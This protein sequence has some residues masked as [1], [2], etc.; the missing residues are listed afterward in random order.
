MMNAR[1]IEDEVAP[2]FSRLYWLKVSCHGSGMCEMV[3]IGM[4]DT[5]EP[6]V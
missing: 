5:A 1:T 4:R 3:D 2:A 6:G